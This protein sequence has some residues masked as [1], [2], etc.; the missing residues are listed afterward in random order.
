MHVRNQESGS[1]GRTVSAAPRKRVERC[2]V[3]GSSD[4]AV[5]TRSTTPL[6]YRPRLRPVRVAHSE[7]MLPCHKML[8]R[9][10]NAGNATAQTGLPVTLKP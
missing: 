10:Q 3:T 1:S 9:L 5:A 7:Q 4:G 2:R 8:G 6:Y